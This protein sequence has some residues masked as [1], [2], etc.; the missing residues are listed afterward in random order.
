ME[1]SQ[2]QEHRV[3]SKADTRTDIRGQ[4]ASY[5]ERRLYFQHRTGLFMLFV[6]GGEFR[7]IRWDRS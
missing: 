3:G 2:R 7:V 1:R 5:D 4:V 6:N